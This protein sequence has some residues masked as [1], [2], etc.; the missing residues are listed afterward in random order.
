MALRTLG[1]AL[2]VALS[3]PP[4]AYAGGKGVVNAT[5]SDAATDNAAACRAKWNAL[6]PEAQKAYGTSFSRYKSAGNCTK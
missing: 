3:L 2:I 6:S 4:H 1:L 5:R